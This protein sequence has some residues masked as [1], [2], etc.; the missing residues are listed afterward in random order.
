MTT[1]CFKSE[2]RN[3][4]NID[5]KT[6][7]LDMSPS[8]VVTL[9]NSTHKG[10][11]SACLCLP[12]VHQIGDTAALKIPETCGHRKVL[13]AAQGSESSRLTFH[14]IEVILQPTIS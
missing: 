13:S 6:L 7:N 11:H 4:K 10:R 14:T 5:K 1:L 2:N 8:N 3:Q 9:K 12:A